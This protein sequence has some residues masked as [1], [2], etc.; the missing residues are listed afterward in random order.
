MATG[1]LKVAIMY[2]AMKSLI[3]FDDFHLIFYSY[4][5][6]PHKSVTLLRQVT[7]K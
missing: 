1:L 7:Y 3:S 4:F 2:L 6:V 5:T